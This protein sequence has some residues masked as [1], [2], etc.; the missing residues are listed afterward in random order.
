MYHILDSLIRM[1]APVLVHTAEEAWAAMQY[2]SQ[3]IDSIHLATMPQVDDSIVPEQRWEKIMTLRDD[4]LKVLEELRR[5][6]QINSNQEASVKITFGDEEMV[7]LL[8]D[9]GIEQFAALCIVSEVILETAQG[10][11]KI[12]AQKSPHSKCQR[13]WNYWP[14]VGKIPDQPDLCTRCA[15]AVVG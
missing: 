12:E 6:K 3:N 13:C 15:K 14:S 7:S 2:K 11:T 9:F 8:N 4:A 5:T 10:E 1:L